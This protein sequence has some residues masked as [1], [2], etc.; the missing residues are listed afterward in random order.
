MGRHVHNLHL[1]AIEYVRKRTGC[2]YTPTLRLVQLYGF[3]E[4]LASQGGGCQFS[5]AN[6]CRKTGCSRNTLR[7]DL[8]I[9]SRHG[10]VTFESGDGSTGGTQ[11]RLVGLPFHQST[12]VAVAAEGVAHAA[13]CSP[14]GCPV[15]WACTVADAD[16]AEVGGW[17]TA[18]QGGGQQLIRGWS[19]ADQGGGQQLITSKKDLRILK[20]GE[21]EDTPPQA[22]AAQLSAGPSAPLP[23]PDEGEAVPGWQPKPRAW[24]AEKRERVRQLWNQHRPAN[25]AALAEGGVDH[26][27]S[28]TV[29]RSMYG[30]G[31][32][33]A[34]VDLLPQVL[35]YLKR[36]SF[37]GNPTKRFTWDNFFG[38]VSN[39][40][41]HWAQAV[42]EISASPA[43]QGLHPDR[44]PVRFEP[45][46]EQWLPL[47]P[48]LGAEDFVRFAIDLVRSG[49]APREAL[50]Y[51]ETWTPDHPYNATLDG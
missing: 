31:G 6:Y 15:T 23:D 49:Q 40:K 2:D 12:E 7:A 27:R 33:T 30:R 18:D 3:L 21:E 42:D 29:A 35:E 32:Y 19:T 43:D 48:N 8:Q 16:P 11:A 28:N 22:V 50:Q 47:V 51:L 1:D 36:D 4:H 41:A 44:F 39:R 13:T 46:G 38:T 34:F 10:W 45:F 24:T 37:W 9:L 5:Q 25:F 26:D 20:K 14:E 17:S